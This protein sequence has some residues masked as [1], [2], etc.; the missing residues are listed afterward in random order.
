MFGLTVAFS[1]RAR[2]DCAA[3]PEN[4]A[5][6][7]F[8]AG[9]S[10]Y[11]DEQ[12]EAALE[13]FRAAYDLRPHPVVLFNVALAE[14][15][16]GDLIEA[17]EHLDQV[18]DDPA[19]PE[20]LLG[21]VRTEREEVARRVATVSLS[22]SGAQLVVDGKSAAGDPPSMRV[23]PGAHEVAIVIDGKQVEHRHLQ[24]SPGETLELAAPARSEPP[25]PV[26]P[27]P[28]QPPP[29]PPPITEPPEERS[30]LAPGWVYGGAAVTVGLAGVTIWSGLD[31][32]RAY[33]S[34]QDEV[35]DLAPQEREERVDAGRAKQRRTN[36]LV[37]ATSAVGLATV[38]T[39]WFLVEWPA[40]RRGS[41]TVGPG[42]LSYRYHF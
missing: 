27:N 33:R 24:L 6:Q 41:L 40:S 14:A 34:Y 9:I 37:G 20:P 4:C 38:A 21:K 39:G 31:T 19:T 28:P 23:N 18:Y 8:E 3:A 29:P 25:P 26:D 22:D 36:V 10:A 30:R 12:F 35:D 7:A 5:K 42:T 32:R 11:Q 2:A 17:L 13:Q 16:V 1:G 15:R